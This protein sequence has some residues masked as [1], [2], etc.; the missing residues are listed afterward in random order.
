MNFLSTL[1]N[2]DEVVCIY[3]FPKTQYITTNIWLKYC[4][5]EKI[6]RRQKCFKD[7]PDINTI[8]QGGL[9]YKLYVSRGQL[10]KGIVLEKIQSI[11]AGFNNGQNQETNQETNKESNK[12]TNKE[13]DDCIMC[14]QH[15]EH[16]I[17]AFPYNN[18]EFKEEIEKNLASDEFFLIESIKNKFFI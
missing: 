3:Y 11:V 8:L 9:W 10:E 1:K 6:T 7:D 14:I 5:I 4:Q 17:C 16:K 12:E 15:N 2:S 18:P 13:Y